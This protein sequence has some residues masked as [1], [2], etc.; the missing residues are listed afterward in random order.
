MQTKLTGQEEQVIATRPTDNPEAYDAYLRGAYFAFARAHN[1]QSA[2]DEFD[3]LKQSEQLY[4]RAIQLDPKFA[5]AIACYSKLESWILHTFERTPERREKAQTLAERALQLQ[6]DMPEAHLARGFSYYYGDNNYDAALKEFQIAQRGL[7]NEPEVY[8][9]IGSIQRRQGK[10]AESTAILE[11]GVTLDP[12]DAFALRNLTFTYWVRRNFDKAN[13]T[14]DRAIALDPTMLDALRVKSDL[15]I[16]EK[17]DFSVAEKAYEAVQSVPLTDEQKLRIAFSRAKISLLERKEQEALRQVESLRD[18]QV[19]GLPDG[20]WTKYYYIGSA[21]KAL[22]DEAEARTAFQ[23]AKSASEEQLKRSPDSW[24]DHM[25]SA[26]ALAQL[27]EKDAALAEAQRATEL[28]PE[29]KDVLGGVEITEGVAEVHTI[30]GDNGRAI[31]MLDGLL[32]RPSYVTV[33][34]LKINPIWDPLRGDPAFQK[35]CQEKQP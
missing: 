3:K 27:G 32:S 21:R 14:L 28:L 9:A 12:N 8:R 4:A 7:P 24:D 1:L 17:G 33:E 2:N 25:Q 15:A 11:K 22:H 34:Y 16:C 5:L 19:A 13:K 6:P 26:K 20:L 31:K 10:W 30:L 23:K 18:D 29:S 35:L